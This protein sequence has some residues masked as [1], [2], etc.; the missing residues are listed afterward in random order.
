M[1]IA[2]YVLLGVLVISTC[3]TAALESMDED[4]MY[5]LGVMFISLIFVLPFLLFV[6]FMQVKI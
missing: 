2:S 3:V 6:I 1:A 5:M 4:Y